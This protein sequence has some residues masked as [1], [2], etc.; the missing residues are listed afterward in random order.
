[1]FTNVQVPVHKSTTT[2]VSLSGGHVLGYKGLAATMWV[3]TDARVPGL[4]TNAGGNFYL[5]GG[6]WRA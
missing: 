3:P 1:M 2:I 5:G 4:S 6:G